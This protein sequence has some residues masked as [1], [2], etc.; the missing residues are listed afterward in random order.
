MRSEGGG[1]QRQEAQ[2]DNQASTAHT[3]EGGHGS[4]LGAQSEGGGVVLGAQ[5]EGRVRA[6]PGSSSQ[7]LI[8][9]APWQL[10]AHGA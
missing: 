7:A 8:R 4:A 5:S 1:G 6:F 9:R 3:E 2:Q 10:R